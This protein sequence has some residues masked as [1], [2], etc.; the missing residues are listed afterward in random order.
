MDPVAT[1]F[2]W[3]NA[4]FPGAWILV[5]IGGGAVA[6]VLLPYLFARLVAPRND[7][8]LISVVFYS[9]LLL[10]LGGVTAWLWYLGRVPGYAPAFL[11][12]LGLMTTY[13]SIAEGLA[14][15]RLL[16]RGVVVEGRVLALRWEVRSI[17]ARSVKYAYTFQ[18][19]QFEESEYYRWRKVPLE[20]GGPVRVVVDPGEPETVR[21]AAN[22]GY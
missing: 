9:G 10:P 20:V 6:F 21:L 8:N 11:L 1:F 4:T 22:L 2:R 13:A 15:G 17:Y 3:A 14:V 5:P 18:G 7:P 16:R 19:K 12:A